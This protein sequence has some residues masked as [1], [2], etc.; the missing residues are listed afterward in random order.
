[1]ETK[2]VIIDRALIRDDQ[3]LEG[4][5]ILAFGQPFDCPHRAA[6]RPGSA[7]KGDP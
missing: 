4:A 3:L 5:A 6:V 2:V 7:G 1:M